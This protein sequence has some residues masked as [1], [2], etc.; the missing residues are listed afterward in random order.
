MVFVL[1]SGCLYRVF[2]LW[3]WYLV[4]YFSPSRLDPCFVFVGVPLLFFCLVGFVDAVFSLLFSFSQALG[5]PKPPSGG[6]GFPL[7][8]FIA[9]EHYDLDPFI[10]IFSFTKVPAPPC[11]FFLVG[12]RVVVSL[13]FFSLLCL[14]VWW[15]VLGFF[16]GSSALHARCIMHSL[17][18]GRETIV[19]P[20]PFI[21]IVFFGNRT[22]TLCLVGFPPSRRGKCCPFFH[23][24]F[25][26]GWFGVFCRFFTVLLFLG[27]LSEK[28][29]RERIFVFGCWCWS[30]VFWC[31]FA[32]VFALLFGFSL[33]KMARKN[34]LDVRSGVS[35]VLSL[36]LWF[37]RR[38]RAF[39]F[40]FLREKAQVITGH[41]PTRTWV[42]FSCSFSCPAAFVCSPFLAVRPAS[43]CFLGA[44][45]W[46]PRVFG[47]LLELF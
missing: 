29:F 27:S 11:F 45:F 9:A 30:C 4:W 2:C 46:A 10:F 28:N 8:F 35:G 7:C 1:S 31:C 24:V 17:F 34:S 22:V 36:F 20:L 16:G 13:V 33:P 44:P 21:I 37:F 39:L 15:S 18:G 32:Y 12:S 38:R 6:L 41:T 26:C 40:F 25:F 19:S 23:F 43:W 14:S 3:G 5:K 42:V 47:I